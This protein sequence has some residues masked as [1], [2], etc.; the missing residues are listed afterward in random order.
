MGQGKKK[1]LG[2]SREEKIGWLEKTRGR[3]RDLSPYLEGNTLHYIK[4]GEIKQIVF[5]RRE[6]AEE[7]LEEMKDI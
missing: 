3:W 5:A 1:D 4:A 6:D 2:D 7:R